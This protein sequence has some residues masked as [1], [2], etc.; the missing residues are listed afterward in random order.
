MISDLQKRTAQAIVNIFETGRVPGDYRAVTL[1]PGDAGH[2]SY[3]RSQITLASGNLYLLIKSYCED[4][5]AQYATHLRNYLD[6]LANRDTILDHDAEFR[7]LLARAGDDLVMRNVQDWFFDK[8]Y[9]EPALNAA[10]AIGI[11]SAL[12]TTVVYDSHIHGSWR[13]MR[14]RTNEAQGANSQTIEQH[15]VR[16][17]VEER[18]K[19]LATHANPLLH[20]TVYRMDTFLQLIDSG[21][22]ELSLPLRI[23]GIEI[24]EGVLLGETVRA[25]AY[26]DSEQML[27]LASPP[28]RGD[29]VK[30]VQEALKEANF[31]VTIDGV[32]GKETEEAVRQFQKARG[33]PADGIVGPVTRSALG[34]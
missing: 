34:L 32:F 19:W 21:K 13:L 7:D 17:Y 12:G 11:S 24:N 2:L 26:D 16:F 8:V 28:I 4:A 22:W 10:A 1:I 15:W 29:E 31:R 27:R 18:R 5:E 14:D 30:K 6:P 33:L 20:R 25:S 23:R 3:G 9:W